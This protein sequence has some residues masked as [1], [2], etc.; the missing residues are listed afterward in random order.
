MG[1]DRAA[2]QA[3]DAL[4]KF[5]KGGLWEDQI[6]ENGEFKKQPVKASSLYHIVNALSEYINKR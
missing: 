5:F 6:L 2:D 4:F 3:F 1:D